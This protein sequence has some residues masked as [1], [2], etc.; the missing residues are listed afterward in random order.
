MSTLGMLPSILKTASVYH[1]RL[2]PGVATFA[3]AMQAMELGFY[4]VRVY[5][6]ELHLCKQF[7]QY[8]PQ[9]KLY[10]MDISWEH[11]E[12]FLDLPSVAAVGLSNPTPF[13]M[14]QIGESLHI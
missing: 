9:L 14:L 11:I 12:Q 10:P 4:N 1:M 5:P 2:L 3:D 7:N 6:G 13:Q 8:I